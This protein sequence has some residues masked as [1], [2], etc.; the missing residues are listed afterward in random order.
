VQRAL[1]ALVNALG[2][3]LVDDGSLPGLDA[4]IEEYAKPSQQEPSEEELAAA[5]AACKAIEE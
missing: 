4:S 5:A 3:A 1:D 2:N